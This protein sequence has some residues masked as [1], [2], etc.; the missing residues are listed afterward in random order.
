MLL[1]W[2]VIFQCNFVHFNFICLKL[3]DFWNIFLFAL[4]F[5]KTIFFIKNHFEYYIIIIEEN[6]IS[7]NIYSN[8]IIFDH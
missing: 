4:E 3:S 5:S 7:T 1:C 6:V 8:R 2:I